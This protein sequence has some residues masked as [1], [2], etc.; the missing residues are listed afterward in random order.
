MVVATT[1]IA[2]MQDVAAPHLLLEIYP[3][4]ETDKLRGMMERLSCPR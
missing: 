2:L 4:M 1:R 3:Q